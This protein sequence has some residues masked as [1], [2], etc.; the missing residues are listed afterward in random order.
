MIFFSFVLLAI[1]FARRW[2]LFFK[3]PRKKTAVAAMAEAEKPK[4][5][6]RVGKKD[7]EKAV[8]LC[9]RADALIKTGKDDDAIKCLVQALSLNPAD[10]EAQQKLAMLYLQKQMFSAAAVLFKQL[11]EVTGD[12]VHFSH[13]GLS[14][15]QAGE[16]GAARDAYQKAVSLDDS[17]PARFISLAHVYRAIGQPYNAIAA[18]NKAVEKEPENLDF[19]FLLADLHME[20]ENWADAAHVLKKI[21]EI[22]KKNKEAKKLLRLAEKQRGA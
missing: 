4:K 20:L 15:Y 9:H 18:A 1:V 5:I 11:G 3:K 6:K 14:L 22:D 7:L 13:L 12:P 2:I 8:A 21:L 19:L 16:L 17:R 10:V